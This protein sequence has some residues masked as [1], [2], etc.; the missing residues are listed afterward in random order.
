MSYS[1]SGKLQ[2]E[3]EEMLN[4]KELRVRLPME[5]LEVLLEPEQDLSD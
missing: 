1:E 2:W 3:L 4:E 5:E